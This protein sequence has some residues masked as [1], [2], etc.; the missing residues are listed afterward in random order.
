MRSRRANEDGFNLVELLVV[1]TIISLLA[2]IM[3]PVFFNQ[4]EK[5][6]QATTE[7]ALKNAATALNSAAISRGGSYRDISIPELVANEGL[8][9]DERAIDLVVA[10]ANASN[11][12]LEAFHESWNQTLYYDSASARP[13]FTD[14]SGNY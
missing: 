1:V 13:D 4:R 8:K 10:S 11:Y 5:A 6:W 14:C 2:S 9:Y 7:S 3:V 12:C